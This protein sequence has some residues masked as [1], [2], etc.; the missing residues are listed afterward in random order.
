[1][2]AVASSLTELFAPSIH[3]RRIAGMLANY[4]F[5]D[6]RV[7]AY[8][9]RRLDQAPKD[10]DFALDYVKRNART[11]EQQRGVVAALDVQDRRAVG[12]ARR[13]SPRLCERRD[14]AR[15][16][17]SGLKANDDRRSTQFAAPSAARRAAEA[18][19]RAGAVDPARAGADLRGRRR[20]PPRCSSS[21]TASATSTRSSPS[22]QSASC[23]GGRDRE[24]R[25]RDAGR[26]Q[27]EESARDM[28]AHSSP[29]PAPPIG[30]LVELTHRCPLGC[31]L[32]LEPARARAAR[33]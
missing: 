15:R 29:P 9:R 4:S 21:A 7:V 10:A 18:R 33:R 19:R 6:E 12:A 28:T 26:P 5:I 17:P 25:H 13:A 20:S 27:G 22:S 14:P 1:M 16:V 2:E 31:S 24:G 32:L 8:F 23:A 30:L 3:R 11:I